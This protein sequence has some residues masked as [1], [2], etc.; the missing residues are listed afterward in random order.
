MFLFKNLFSQNGNNQKNREMKKKN[1]ENPKK[2]TKKKKKT[3]GAIPKV[4]KA[5]LH[6]LKKALPASH[7]GA[8]YGS[9]VFFQPNLAPKTA[10]ECV[11]LS[12]NTPK[13]PIFP[14][15]G[16]QNAQK[17]PFFRAFFFFFCGCFF[18]FFRK[19]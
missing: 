1:K 17:H 14:L 16:P 18:F 11:F 15:L 7:F 19:C 13:S 10:P 4:E 6:L 3:M 2:D 5:V 9:G 12:K 8:A